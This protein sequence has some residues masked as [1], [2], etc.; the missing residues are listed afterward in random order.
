MA[1]LEDLRQTLENNLQSAY[2]TEEAIQFR[3]ELE[4][5]FDDDVAA[6]FQSCAEG[7]GPGSSFAECVEIVAENE[8][9]SSEAKS[10][11]ESNVPDAVMNALMSV[12]DVWTADQ[13]ETIREISMSNN[14]DSLNRSCAEGEYAEVVDELSLDSQPS[15]FQDCVT[16]VAEAQDIRGELKSAY[17]T[18]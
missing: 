15:N 3:Q 9:L 13:R 16:I 4:D 12:G 6:S 17:G 7:Q 2:S 5:N 8:D 14:I 18:N 1:D 10:A 11:F